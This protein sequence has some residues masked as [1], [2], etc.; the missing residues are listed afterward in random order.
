MHYFY[1][2]TKEMFADFFTKPLKR[3]TFL[4]LRSLLAATG[5]NASIVKIKVMKNIEKDKGNEKKK[6]EGNC[7]K[8]NRITVIGLVWCLSKNGIIR[9]QRESRNKIFRTGKAPALLSF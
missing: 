6:S 5:G 2:P 4:R 1:Y 9:K 7:R 3:V 8:R